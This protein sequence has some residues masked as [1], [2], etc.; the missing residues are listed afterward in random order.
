MHRPHIH[1]TESQILKLSAV[2]VGLVLFVIAGGIFV[3]SQN[4][5]LEQARQSQDAVANHTQTLRQIQTLEEDINTAVTQL[6]SSNAADHEQTVKYINCVLVGV[7][8][9][10]SPSQALVV[11]QEC[12]GASGAQ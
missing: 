6:K 2:I 1:L 4:V 10:P 11:Y 8:N 12:L 9:S 3:N 5:R 7:T